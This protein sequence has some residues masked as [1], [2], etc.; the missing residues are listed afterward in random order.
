MLRG[1]QRDKEAAGRAQTG[2]W[3][4]RLVPQRLVL[5]LAQS[6]RSQHADALRVLGEPPP[7]TVASL[8]WYGQHQAQAA[9]GISPRCR[10][11][12]GL[13]RP[14]GSVDLAAR[15][16]LRLST[17]QLVDPERPTI[18]LLAGDRDDSPPR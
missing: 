6:R 10:R 1:S 5:A 12:R 9:G 14:A 4:I 18:D 15:Y 8:P 16:A 11:L 7:I 13:A 3:M 2:S 17:D